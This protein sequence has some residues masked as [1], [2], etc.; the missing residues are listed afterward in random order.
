MKWANFYFIYRV[1]TLSQVPYCLVCYYI[2]Y[3]LILKISSLLILLFP[4]QKWRNLD[5][6]YFQSQ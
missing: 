5:I 4:F 3:H 2:Y 1:Y 6:K